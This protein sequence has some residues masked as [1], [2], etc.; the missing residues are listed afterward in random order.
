MPKICKHSRYQF[1]S[2]SEKFRSLIM[3]MGMVHY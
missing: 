3:N 1:L 2:I